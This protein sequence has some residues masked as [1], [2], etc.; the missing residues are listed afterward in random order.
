MPPHRRFLKCGVAALAVSLLAAPV[1][2]AQE[3]SPSAEG[4][5][6]QPGGASISSPGGGASAAEQSAGRTGVSGF[7]GSLIPG[8]EFGA[9]VDLS[10]SYATNPSG[11]SGSRTDWLTMLGLGLTM[12]EHSARVSFDASYRGA[13]N[14]YADGTQ[15]TQFTNDLQAV[16]AVI[17]I[18]EYVNFNASAFAQPVVISNL[19][20][21]TA[22]NNVASNGFRNAYG[23]SAGPTIMFHLG[24]F[25]TSITRGTFGASYFTEPEGT[26]SFTGIPGV[27]GPQN[28]TM[29]SFSETLAS[30]TDFSRLS[31]NVNATLQEMD[32]P[33]GLFTEKVGLA[34]FQYAITRSIS[35]LGTGGYDA[36]HNTLSL[37]R[38]LSGPV[39]TGGLALT[40]GEDFQLQFEIGEK[41]NDLSYQ[42]TMRWNITPT[43]TLDGS[44]TDQVTTPEGQLLGN[45]SSLVSTASGGLASSSALYSNGTA[46]SMASFNAQSPG[47]LSFDQSISRF[48]TVNL[49]YSQEFPRDHATIGVFAT[50]QT[51]LTTVFV[52]QPVNNS[53]GMVTS[54]SHDIS[55]QLSATLGGGYTNYEELGGHANVYTVNG[56]LAY[57]L[58]PDTNVYLR[59]DYLTR[60]SSTALQNL[61]PFTGNV[62]DLR[63][64]I[65]LSHR[66]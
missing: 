12:N 27:G 33:Q 42:G 61:S 5:A 14:F 38:N 46:S 31:W 16:A 22:N 48:Q 24:D 45:L 59:T 35:L 62:D 58:S 49:N 60:D 19:G 2:N 39:G 29:R 23:F 57:T 8:F 6:S 63:V 4:G 34:H 32:R 15:S 18:P 7:V 37:G 11:F 21:V 65:G 43:G 54:F 17:V 41:Y 55:R 36:I 52:G 10:E 53:W 47:S 64:T 56:Q 9:S 40:L 20:A 30:G 44:V 1:S 26:S 50:R 13:V 25:A 66:L 51:I 28:T 3:R